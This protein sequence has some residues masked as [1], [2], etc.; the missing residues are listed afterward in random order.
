VL[1]ILLLQVCIIANL[2]KVLHRIYLSSSVMCISYDV[3]VN[4]GVH[5]VDYFDNKIVS[6]SRVY[7]TT[8]HVDEHL[9]Q[10]TFSAF[11]LHGKARC[12]TFLLSVHVCI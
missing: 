5:D 7:F 8:S 9:Y 2:L 1:F 4:Y 11:T 3:P 6:I 12:G 10:Y